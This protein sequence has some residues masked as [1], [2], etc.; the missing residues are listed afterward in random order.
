M[1]TVKNG[2][3]LFIFRCLPIIRSTNQTPHPV[4]QAPCVRAL[5]RLTSV[6]ARSPFWFYSTGLDFLSLPQ[7]P[8]IPSH[9]QAFVE[10]GLAAW[11]PYVNA[12]ATSPARPFLISP[13]KV[14]CSPLRPLP[15]DSAFFSQRM[16]CYLEFPCFCFLFVCY[17]W[18]PFNT[19][20]AALQQRPHPPR[21]LR[22]CQHLEQF[23]GHSRCS[24]NTH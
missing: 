15:H 12:N 21:S 22:Y 6:S 14:A 16:C 1:G 8:H 13:F 5:A 3:L 18:S 10:S 4:L 11:A 9:L 24:I 2:N 20:K 23:R 17:C 19:R 7:S